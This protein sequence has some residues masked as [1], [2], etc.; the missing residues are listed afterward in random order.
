VQAP[1]WRELFTSA[2][3]AEGSASKQLAPHHQQSVNAFNSRTPL[4]VT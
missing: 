3:S 4:V 2:A 1:V